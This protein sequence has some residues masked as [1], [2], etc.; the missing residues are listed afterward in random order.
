MAKNPLR[1]H[2]GFLEEKL[3][4]SME[5]HGVYKKLE[6]EDILIGS[7]SSITHFPLILGG[8]F[9]II[10]ENEEG[11]EHY[12]YHLFEGQACAVSLVCC[13]SRSSSKI[14]AIAE[15]QAEV[16]MIP[17]EYND[18]WMQDFASWKQYVATTYQQRFEEL[19]ETIDNIAFLKMDEKV[20][21]YLLDKVEATGQT[22]LSVTHQEIAFEL[23]TT[24]VVVS[25]LLKQ[26]EKDNKLKLHRNKIVVFNN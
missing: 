25:R 17:T 6:P 14:K 23:N 4:E 15:E 9:R 18:L 16:L 26:L 24:R 8:S 19:L 12:L 21:N 22:E 5:Q 7:G 1:K 13:M 2:F 3:L 10:R 11:K 20:W